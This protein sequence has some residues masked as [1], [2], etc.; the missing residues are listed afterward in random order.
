MAWINAL[1]QGI[2]LGGLYALFA[3]GQALVFGV[4]RLDQPGSRRLHHPPGVHLPDHGRRRPGFNPFY[5][6]PITMVIMFIIGYA[7]QRG[8]LNRIVGSKIA[9]GVIVTFGISMV[10]QNG[11]LVVFTPD[12]QGLDA[13]A[14]EN[15]SVSHR[16]E[17]CQ[18]AGCR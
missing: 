17:P 14:I 7:L 12:S 13:G 6:I 10:I 8:V 5:S 3:T 18:S 1:I 15:K 9:I 4:M 11:L 2:L 16:P